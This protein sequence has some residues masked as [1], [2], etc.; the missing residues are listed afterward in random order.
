MQIIS[1]RGN[2]EGPNPL[3]ENHPN[4]LYKALKA[5]HAIECDIWGKDDRL[6]LGHDK[7]EWE[8]PSFLISG[9]NVYFHCKNIQAYITLYNADVSAYYFMHENDAAGL[10]SDGK[11][12]VHPHTILSVSEYDKPFCYAVLP[13]LVYGTQAPVFNFKTLERFGGV[14]TD[15]VTTFK[16]QYEQH[17]NTVTN[18]G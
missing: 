1:H 12:W 18:F 10:V 14:C 7:P 8:V 9:W 16:D 4:Y 2:L 6:Y 3:E 5:G 11:L 15:Y 13:E 17:I